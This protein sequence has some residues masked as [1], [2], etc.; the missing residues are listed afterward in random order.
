MARSHDCADQRR[1]RKQ[2]E[3]YARSWLQIER[4]KQEPERLPPASGPELRAVTKKAERL[5][6]GTSPEN[7]QQRS[8]AIRRCVRQSEPGDRV[9]PGNQHR[10]MRARTSAL[11]RG[12]LRWSR[13]IGLPAASA[14][15]R[16]PLRARLD[17]AAPS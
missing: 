10:F 4:V 8:C 7:R 9:R 13:C 5:R 3:G 11:L 14:A 16:A 12:L 2:G 6:K 1:I 17:Y 15:P